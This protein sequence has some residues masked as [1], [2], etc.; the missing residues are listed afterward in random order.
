MSNGV[1]TGMASKTTYQR[2]PPNNLQSKLWTD[3]SMDTIFYAVWVGAL[4]Y[5]VAREGVE[6]SKVV[7]GALAVGT[8]ALVYGRWWQVNVDYA[9]VLTQG[10]GTEIRQPTTYPQPGGPQSQHTEQPDVPP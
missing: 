7:S 5:A 4:T 8:G 3:P 1:G 2:S 9:R 6:L 10:F